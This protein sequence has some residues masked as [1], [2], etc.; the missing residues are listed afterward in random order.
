MLHAAWARLRHL[1]S[2][3]ALVIWAILL[4][5]SLMS[6]SLGGGLSSDDHIQRLWVREADRC[7]DLFNFASGDGDSLRWQK[8]AGTMPWYADEAQKISFFRPLASLS[9]CID[10]R[11]LDSFPAALHLQNLIWMA[12]AIFLSFLVY[13][14]TATSLWIAGAATWLFAL[15]ES[16]GKTVGWIANRNMLM[17]ATFGMAALFFHIRA[18]QKPSKRDI[19]LASLA[20]L[21]AL[22]SAEAA[23]TIVGYLLAYTV[24]LD[25]GRVSSR[26]RA[27]L[28]YAAIILVWRIAYT[29]LDHG[30]YGTA[31]YTDPVA[32]PLRYL[33][34]LI[35]RAPVLL[36]TQLGG[37]SSDIFPLLGR[38]D[39]HNAW[40]FALVSL[41]AM[42]AVLLPLLRRSAQARFFALGTLLALLPASATMPRDR[43]LMLA[44]FGGIG[45]VAEFFGHI[46]ESK[47]QLSKSLLLRVPAFV[48]LGFWLLMHAV[49]APFRLPGSSLST[50]DNASVF[51]A[52]SESLFA[53]IEPSGGVVVLDGG[54]LMYS[55]TFA[56]FLGHT[57][58]KAKDRYVNCFYAN[59][60]GI[61]VFRIGARRL[62]L[63]PDVGFVDSVREPF[64]NGDK[65]MKVGEEINLGWLH[66]TVTETNEAG[67]PLEAMLRFPVD[68]DD[69]R[70]YLRYLD[71]KTLA[72]IDAPVPPIRGRYR[73]IAGEI[74]DKSWPEEAPAPRD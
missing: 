59:E 15:D 60:G 74:V 14:Q 1:L 29:A 34:S 4:S 28:P 13:R 72:Y 32:Q 57:S 61:S 62:V 31:L 63:R 2:K 70:I 25:R 50:S 40:L 68:L 69:P 46:W 42:A 9:H 11:Y 37:P 22:L 26:L 52:A 55:C 23:L 3:P 17:V 58:G 24:F 6:P 38:A 8:I 18:R 54:D 49:V 16:H 12:A 41:L 27:L 20:F 7:A 56:A 67:E 19:I 44:S 30:Q 5:L 65:G 45:L 71:P 48:L 64:W 10:Y 35:E 47:P 21:A 51:E 43:L 53:H 39:R 66:I 73:I 33:Q 36:F